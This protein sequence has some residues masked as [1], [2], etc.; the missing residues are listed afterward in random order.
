MGNNGRKIYNFEDPA[1]FD[2]AAAEAHMD[3]EQPM[4][5][6]LEVLEGDVVMQDAPYGDTHGNTFGTGF[7][8]TSSIMTM[9]QN[10]QV[11]QYERY[12]E[13]C[14]RRDAFESTK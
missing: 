13:D 6:S 3:D 4:G 5:A 12:E 2:V 1:E 7:G 8:D 9:L 11:R 14:R 10:M